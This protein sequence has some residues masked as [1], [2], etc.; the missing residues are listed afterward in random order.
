MASRGNPFHPTGSFYLLMRMHRQRYL[1]FG[2]VL[3][4]F[5][6]TGENDM[7]TVRVAANFFE[8]GEHVN[9]AFNDRWEPLG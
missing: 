9:G 2:I 6:W 4:F 1:R 3:V 7:R 5:L 8:N